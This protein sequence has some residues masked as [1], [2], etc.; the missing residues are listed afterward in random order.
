MGISINL[1]NYSPLKRGARGV[2]L[3]TQ[4]NRDAYMLKYSNLVMIVGIMFLSACDIIEPPYVEKEDGEII[5]T[6]EFPVPSF[7]SYASPVKKIMID[8][9]T[10]HKCVKCPEAHE[11]ASDIKDIYGEQVEILAIHA[12]FFAKTDNDKYTYDFNT[13]TGTEINEYFETGDVYPIGMINRIE[14]NGSYLISKDNWATVIDTLVNKSPVAYL[15]IVNDYHETDHRLGTHI[16]TEFLYSLSGEYL[17]AVYVIEDSIIS[18]QKSEDI[19]G[20]AIEIEDYVHLH[21][22]RD[23]MNGTWGD[24]IINGNISANF[25]TTMSYA[26]T[27]NEAWEAKNC[28]VIAFV[29]DNVTKEILQVEQKKITE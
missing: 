19:N 13:E 28:S 18:T 4:V 29:Y 25:D 10:G 14:S 7:T 26:Y 5:D 2:Y 3:K 12:G 6:T 24:P 20:D 21:V 9:F 8:E 1:L 17:L 11:I 23:D 16:N 27:L 22:L 15:Q